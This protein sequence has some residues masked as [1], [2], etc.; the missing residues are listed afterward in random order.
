MVLSG[1]IEEIVYRNNDN[2]YT[3]AVLDVNGEPITCVGRFPPITEGEMVEVNG[4]FIKHTKYG[5]QFAVKSI[6]VSKPTSLEGIVRYLSSGLIKGVG[7]ITALNIVQKFGKDT[8]DIIEFNPARLSEVKGISA[9]K[10]Q[11]IGEA[12][13]DIKKMQNSI[14][15]NFFTVFCTLS[16]YV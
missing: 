14:L 15:F 13:N 2:N 11:D 16:C 8:L 5:E 3:V 7:P 6:K 9:N 10:A 12:F 1:I 4:E